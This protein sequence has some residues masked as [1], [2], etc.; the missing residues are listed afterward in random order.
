MANRLGRRGR[1][2]LLVLHYVTALGWLGG[3]ASQLTLNLVA[4]STGD[5]ALRHAAYEIAHVFDISLLTV[6]SLGSAVTGILL[7]VRGPWGLVRHWWVAVKL[8]VTVALIV[9]VPAVVGGWI[10]A[11]VRETEA[12]PGGPGYPTVGGE[13][14]SSSVVI[15]TVLVLVTV[16]SV[17]KPWGRIRKVHSGRRRGPGK[18]CSAPLRA[19]TVR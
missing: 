3:G 12:G 18:P 17:V 10:R 14:L 8:A 1:Q 13:L 11:A 2:T 6:L 7:A 19:L 4:L 5:P 9:L 16:I 15:V